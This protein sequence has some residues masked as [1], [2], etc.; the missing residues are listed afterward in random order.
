M[1]PLGCYVIPPL[2]Y[3]QIF[4]LDMHGDGVDRMQLGIMH[5]GRIGFPSIIG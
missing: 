2:F 3:C 5:K 1:N 4:R